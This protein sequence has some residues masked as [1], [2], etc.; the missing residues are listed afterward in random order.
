MKKCSCRSRGLGSTPPK[1]C[2][3]DILFSPDAGF[4][5]VD[6]CTNKI[7]DVASSKQSA[8][9]KAGWN[10]ELKKLHKE[11]GTRK[12]ERIHRRSKKMLEEDFPGKW[13]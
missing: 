11:I 5:I 10:K 12:Q 9:R 2:K 6:L 7:V 4:L 13:W 3:R 1:K 8:Y